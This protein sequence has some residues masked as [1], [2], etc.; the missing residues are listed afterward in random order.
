MDNWQSQWPGWIDLSRSSSNCMSSKQPDRPVRYPGERSRWLVP[1]A[2]QPAYPVLVD[3]DEY[4][5]IGWC[6]CEDFQFRHQPLLERGE[7]GTDKRCKHILAVVEEIVRTEG[8]SVQEARRRGVC[9]ICGNRVSAHL[10]N[11][12]VFNYGKEHAH[13]KCLEP[14]IP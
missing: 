10:R 2:S 11:P 9:R 7:R 6:A 3:M 5:G 14:N 1:S 12:F 13:Q 4:D 8:L